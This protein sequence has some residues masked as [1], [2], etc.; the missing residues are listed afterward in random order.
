MNTYTN[1]QKQLSLRKILQKMNPKYLLLCLVVLVFSCNFEKPSEKFTI[2]GTLDGDYNDYIYLSYP[3]YRDSVY[4]IK[5]SVKVIDG[6]FSFE[7]SVHFPVQAWFNLKPSSTIEWLYLENSNI[8]INGTYSSQDRNGELF[9]AIVFDSI[10]G[11]KSQDLE[12][13]YAAFYQK[14]K[15][16][17]DF[18]TKLFN[19]VKRF[20]NEHPQ[21]SLSGRILG[22]IAAL[23]S[24]FTYDQVK[25]IYEIIDTTYQGTDDLEMIKVGLNK[26]GAFSIG[27][28]IL[29]FE[30]P[31]TNNDLLSTRAFR[32]KTTLIDFWASWCGPC[33]VKHPKY[34][35]LYKKY[36]GDS[37]DILSVSI[38][39]STEPWLKAI[40]A[41][42]ITWKNVIDTGGYNGKTATSYFINAIPASYLIDENGKIIGNNLSVEKIDEILKSQ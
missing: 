7:G 3:N 41:D 4:T 6:A 38:D 15:N 11:S 35:E 23:S 10:K 16:D 5:D 9:N 28:Q 18:K 19:E 21:H 2:N 36:G 26:L 8:K 17:A 33:R 20:A 1:F 27:D 24:N 30:L 40:D 32:G 37:F 29:D 12:N 14:H 42:S 22:D 13:T 34:R 31:Q 25:E 39:T